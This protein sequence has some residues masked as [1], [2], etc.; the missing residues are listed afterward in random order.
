MLKTSIEDGI[1]IITLSGNIG[2]TEADEIETE[3]REII[4]GSN[5]KIVADMLSV[6]HL[7]SSALGIMVTNKRICKENGGDLKVVFQSDDLKQLFEITMLDKVFDL[8][9]KVNDALVDF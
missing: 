2:A 1:H 8:Y 9:S 7:T 6:S 3:L 5:Y 4:A